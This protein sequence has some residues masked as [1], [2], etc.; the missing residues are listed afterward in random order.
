MRGAMGPTFGAVTV[1]IADADDTRTMLADVLAEFDDCR[2][3]AVAAD[4]EQAI[5]LAAQHCPQIALLHVDVPGGGGAHATR[6]IRAVSPQTRVI[7]LGE[8]DDHE[9]V[10]AML[11]AG[12]RGH[13]PRYTASHDLLRSLRRCAI[14][15]A[16]VADR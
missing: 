11:S 13:L 12:A 7:A 8:A 1:L 6:G 5:D 9:A 16:P 2:V 15:A 4:A 14:P 3:V 10:R